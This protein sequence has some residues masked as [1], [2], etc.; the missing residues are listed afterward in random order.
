MLPESNPP[1]ATFYLHGNNP[2]HSGCKSSG[3]KSSCAGKATIAGSVSIQQEGT[4]K[5]A[6]TRLLRATLAVGDRWT[7]SRSHTDQCSTGD[8]NLAR[9]AELVCERTGD[10][11]RSERSESLMVGDIPERI[12][13]ATDPAPS[14]SI[15]R[16]SADN[17]PGESSILTIQQRL[18]LMARQKREIKC[19]PDCCNHCHRHHCRWLLI[20]HC[21]CTGHIDLRS[22]KQF[23]I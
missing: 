4:T 19:P 2:R 9:S 10:H 23:P 18:A 14:P 21:V 7:S 22:K 13:G 1:V 5:G 17:S 20:G 11:Q 16:A 8:D 15:H 3:K 6:G 12:K